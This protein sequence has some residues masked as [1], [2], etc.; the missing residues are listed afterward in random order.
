M[1]TART[2]VEG[3]PERREPAADQGKTASTERSRIVS[4]TRG[5]AA[6]VLRQESSAE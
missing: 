3:T 6:T 2:D 1:V 4:I 5:N